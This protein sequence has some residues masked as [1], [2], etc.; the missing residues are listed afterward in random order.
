MDEKNTNTAGKSLKDRV[1]EMADCLR[2][3]KDAW[4]K[5]FLVKGYGERFG[6]WEVNPDPVAIAMIADTLFIVTRD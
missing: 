1:P 4:E 3:A 6:K 5:A 2:A